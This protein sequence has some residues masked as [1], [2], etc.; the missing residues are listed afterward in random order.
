M[1]L[2]SNKSK[3][4]GLSCLKGSLWNPKNSS[5][6]E[7]DVINPQFCL[8]PREINVTCTF[9]TFKTQILFFSYV[10]NIYHASWKH[11]SQAIDNHISNSQ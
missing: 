6:H 11:S 1:L 8:F 5:S 2:A 4:G 3:R 10:V 7:K 9:Q